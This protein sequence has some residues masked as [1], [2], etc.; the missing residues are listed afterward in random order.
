MVELDRTKGITVC[1]E[2]GEY[3]SLVIDGPLFNKELIVKKGA[4]IK[5]DNHWFMDIKEVGLVDK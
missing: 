3:H 5:R 1:G 2:A 4:N